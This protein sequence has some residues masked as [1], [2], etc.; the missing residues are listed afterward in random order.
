M[1]EDSSIVKNLIRVYEK[2]KVDVFGICDY[3][4]VANKYSDMRWQ[5]I[6]DVCRFVIWH[7]NN[8]NYEY[9][10][11]Y[12]NENLM[13]DVWKDILSPILLD[14]FSWYTPTWTRDD[15]DDMELNDFIDRCWSSYCNIFKRTFNVDESVNYTLHEAFEYFRVNYDHADDVDNWW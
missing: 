7:Y 13:E 15:A 12:K 9:T 1:E 8:G 5:V 4:I 3:M 14:M 11:D 10:G 6:R 2:Y